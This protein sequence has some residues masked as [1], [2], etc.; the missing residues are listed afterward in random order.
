MEIEVSKK[1]KAV[2]IAEAKGWS[3]RQLIE[4]FIDNADESGKA[5]NLES[6]VADLQRKT[7]D[8]YARLGDLDKNKSK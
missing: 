7:A 3:M 6:Q 2:R 5:P 4:W 1:Q 8:L